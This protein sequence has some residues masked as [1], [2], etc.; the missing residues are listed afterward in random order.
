MRVLVL[1]SLVA[2]AAVALSAQ[3]TKFEA[4]K[5]RL[6][7]EA[8]AARKARNIDLLD[9]KLGRDFPPPVI[10][11]LKVQKVLPGGNISLAL[12]GSIPAGVSVIADRDGAVISGATLTGS[13]YSARMTVGGAEGPGFVKLYAITPVSFSLSV[14]P[15]AFIDTVY[16]FE[17]KGADGLTIKLTPTDKTFSIT[18]ED[19]DA[20]LWYQAEFYKPG[21]SKPFETR[22]ASMFFQASSD[23]QT[24]L[25]ISVGDSL[26]TKSAMEEMDDIGQQLADPNLTQ[27]QRDALMQRLTKAQVRA[28]EEM[29]KNA[30]PQAAAAADKAREDFG[31][32]LIQIDPGAS[33]SAKATVLCGKNFYKGVIQTTGTMAQVK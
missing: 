20:R 30:T 18:N 6:H 27:T 31:C 5:N 15:V 2:T 26:T 24:R 9:P 19:K 22:K 29:L 13:S 23:P 11:R 17:L 8:V 25:D 7:Q 21:E 3:S 4:E 32:R 14:V 12:A 10:Q 33:G 28:T 1:I 16:R